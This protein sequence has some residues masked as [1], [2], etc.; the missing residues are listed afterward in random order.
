MREHGSAA[1]RYYVQGA[2]CLSRQSKAR[3]TSTHFG[4]PQ[5]QPSA[6]A[7]KLHSCIELCWRYRNQ[8]SVRGSSVNVFSPECQQ[9]C[10][11]CIFRGCTQVQQL[12]FIIDTLQCSSSHTKVSYV[13]VWPVVYISMCR[14]K[15]AS[16]IHTS[17]VPLF[18]SR[19]EFSLS[20]FQNCSSCIKG[21]VYNVHYKTLQFTQCTFLDVT[22]EEIIL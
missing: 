17:F 20:L 4:P 11:L 5:E 16:I 15:A 8:N 10:F 3:R 12:T 13:N 18:L 2:V 7:G 14:V 21:P 6:S 9:L 22:A 1:L 19:K